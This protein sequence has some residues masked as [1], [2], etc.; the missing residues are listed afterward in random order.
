MQAEFGWTQSLS[1]KLAV[2]KIGGNALGEAGL[3]DGFISD[4]RTLRDV[5][6]QIVLCHGAGPHISK[7]LS[8]HGI[9]SQFINGQRQTSLEAVEIVREVLTSLGGHIARQLQQANVAAQAIAET[10]PNLLM[11][12][13]LGV[14]VDG[15]EVNLG[16]VG[17]VDQVDVTPLEQLIAAQSIPVISAFARD[18]TDSTLLNVNADLAAATIATSLNADWLVVLSDV[19]GVYSNWP[20]RTSLVA[21]LDPAGIEKLLTIVDTG[22]IPKLTACREAILGGVQRAAIM[23]GRVEHPLLVGKWGEVGTTIGGI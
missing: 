15:R 10:E 16:Q 2:I 6:L 1:G 7:A 23:D 19:E 18:Q 21:N 12:R 5:G 9:V 22:M 20:D 3:T 13:R 8:E 17:V 4:L 14:I 11:G